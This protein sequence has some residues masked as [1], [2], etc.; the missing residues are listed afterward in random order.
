MILR[1]N[2][3]LD[4]LQDGRIALG[5]SINESRDPGMVYA[6]AAAGADTVF[7]DQEH[8]LHNTETVFDLVA[9]AH[10]AGITPLVRPPQ[11]DYAWITRLLDG[12]C[13]SLLIPHVRHP[14]EVEHLIDLAFYH[15]GGRRG[16]AL[17]GGAGVNYQEVTSATDAMRWANENLLIALIIETPEAVEALDELLLPGVGLALVGHG[18]LAQ[19][20]GVPGD[21]RHRLVLEA[22]ERVRAVCAE[23]GIAYGV[24]QPNPHLIADEVA[25]G[26]QLIVHGG[27][28]SFIR[29]SVGNF[30]RTVDEALTANSTSELVQPCGG[31]SVHR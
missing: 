25:L 2:H 28:L 9:H 19:L 20:Y 10:A 21:S 14:S 16:V 11:I 12:G 8:N 24:F 4:I 1:R 17:V 5:C 18:D 27:V 29:K 3:L 6:M 23:R 13:Q 26:A 30:R 31:P 7:I 22:Q 15:P